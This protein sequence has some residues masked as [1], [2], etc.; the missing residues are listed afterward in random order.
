M[1]KVRKKQVS[2]KQAESKWKDKIVGH[3]L[4]DIE[5]LVPHPKNW[6]QHPKRQNSLLAGAIEDVGFI[7]SITVNKRTGRLLDGHLRLELARAKGVGKI[8]VEYVDLSEEE[9]AK[10]LLT[11]DP[12]AGLATP[13]DE[14][15]LSLGSDF[16]LDGILN[17]DLRDFLASMTQQKEI[18]G[19]GTSYDTGGEVPEMYGVVIE[20][21]ND[22]EQ[23][24]LIEE[25]TKRG[26]ACRAL[27]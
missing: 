8:R 3:E 12:I 16:K 5:K 18:G 7:R 19:A 22:A 2:A 21:K 17:G 4:V 26:L 27:M 1:G 24:K 6:R 13:S 20:C 9:E 23:R 14:M 25:F 15:L 10:A 11:L